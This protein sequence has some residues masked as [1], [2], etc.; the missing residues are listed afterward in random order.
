R[1]RSD[2]DG[3]RIRLPLHQRVMTYTRPPRSRKILHTVVSPLARWFGARR[4]RLEQLMR[5]RDEL[6]LLI[7]SVGEAIIQTGP[8]GKLVRANRAARK[9]L[10]LPS[11]AR[12]T[13]IESLVRHP[14]LL[15]RLEAALRGETGGTEEIAL[16][17]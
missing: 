1:G 17:D 15:A 2:R 12:G 9:M 14:A 8:D 5:E 10:G 13:P 3:P 7:E 11:N 4:R 6:V 16:D